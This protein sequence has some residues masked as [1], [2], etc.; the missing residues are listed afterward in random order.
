MRK[1]IERAHE[2][3]ILFNPDKCSLKSD[4]VMFFECLYDKSAIRPDPA[5]VEAI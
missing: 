3:G 5:K 4:S 2:Y 1:L